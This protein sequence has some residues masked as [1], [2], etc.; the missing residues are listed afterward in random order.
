MKDTC[1][2]QERIEHEM[3]RETERQHHQVHEKASTMRQEG[4]VMRTEHREHVR[5]AHK[6]HVRQAMSACM[7]SAAD[8]AAREACKRAMSKQDHGR[9]SHHQDLSR[10]PS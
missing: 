7:D 10:M 3:N 4:D 6:E 9:D 8:G 2:R 1:S 5:Q